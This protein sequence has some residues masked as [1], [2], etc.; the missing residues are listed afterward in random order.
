[1]EHSYIEERDIADRYLSGRLSSEERKRFE[2]HLENC[3]QCLDQL[4]TDDGLRTGLRIV[5]AE[6][7]ERARVNARAGLLAR[8]DRFSR[9][10]KA[11]M[12]A[13]IL[14][15]IA[16]SLGLMILELSSAR[17]DLAQATRS[18]VEWQRKYEEREQ[19]ARNQLKEEPALDRHSSAPQD[20]L[21]AQSERELEV[22]PRAADRVEQATAPNGVVPVFAL[23]VTRSGEPDLSQPDN[24]IGLSP[25]SKLIILLLELGPDPGLQSYRANIST[26]DGRSIWRESRLMP[27][28]RDRLAL[29]FNPRLFKPGDYLLALEGLT[30]ENRYVLTAR[31]TFRVI[32][33]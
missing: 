11:A 25:T 22:R 21:A 16:C 5:A 4:E 15:L 12:L 28:F 17:R 7:V 1:M 2:E 30:A 3:V 31:Y 27:S 9:A 8:V 29:S 24:R 33:Q 14:L 19:A 20:R 32:T 10:S 18:A 13:G 26:A 6:D 23:S